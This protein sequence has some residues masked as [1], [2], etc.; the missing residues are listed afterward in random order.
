MA[1]TATFT[2]WVRPSV[3]GCPEPVLLE[4]IRQSALEFCIRTKLLTEDVNVAI[5]AGTSVY[6]LPIDPAFQAVDILYLKKEGRSLTPSSR[7]DNDQD[8]T[9]ASGSVKNYYLNGL[10]DLVVYPTPDTNETLTASVVVAPISNSDEIPD[11]LL[12]G[13]RYLAIAA[14]AKASLMMMD[15]VPWANPQSGMMA[16]ST[17]DIAI[18]GEQ[19]AR[20]KGTGPKRLRTKLT[21]F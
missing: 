15:A 6:A 18:E 9:I 19:I 4:A 12:L 5:Q 11:E 17:Y 2:K 7:R 21:M 3:P 1:T 10:L 8:E 16:R 14:G 20:A 13:N